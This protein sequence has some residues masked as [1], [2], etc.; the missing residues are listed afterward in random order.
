MRVTP[1]RPEPSDATIRVAATVE[2]ST[3]PAATLWYEVPATHQDWI[4]DDADH[5]LVATVMT[6]MALG[7][8]LHIAG[9]VSARLVANLEAYQQVWHAWVPTMFQRVRVTAD[10]L[11][12]DRRPD[13]DDELCLFSGGVDASWTL[14]R[15]ATDTGRATRSVTAVMVRGMGGFLLPEP[16]LF[17]AALVEA[18]ATTAQLGVDIVPVTTNWER[19]VQGF[20]MDVEKCHAAGFVSCLGV[21]SAH[22]PRGVIASGQ[23]AE[24]VD[25]H[26]SHPTT[27]PLL[28]SGRFE[29]VHHGAGLERSDK[30][31]DL[32]GWPALLPTLR[33]CNIARRTRRNCGRCEKCLRTALASQSVGLEPVG[34]LRAPTVADVRGVAFPLSWNADEWRRCLEQPADTSLIDPAVARAVRRRLWMSDH[35]LPTAADLR[36]SGRRIRRR[37]RRVPGKVWRVIRR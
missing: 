2:P 5:V 35:H 14:L 34:G 1:L 37:I 11:L 19:V 20:G 32:A 12:P 8:D 9:P 22:H 16:E 24:V 3:R 33:V 18:R 10:E 28:G 36:R 6:A 15:R 26:G 13:G 21:V 25:G 29:V 23:G 17:E 4:P 30:L 31:R 7:E 27:D